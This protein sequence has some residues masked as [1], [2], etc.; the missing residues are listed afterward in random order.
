[1]SAHGIESIQYVA[2]LVRVLRMHV[3]PPHRVRRCPP[4]VAGSR[5]EGGYSH[6]PRHAGH[7]AGDMVGR[8]RRRRRNGTSSSRKDRSRSDGRADLTHRVEPTEPEGGLEQMCRSVANAEGGARDANGD[9]GAPGPGVGVG[10][11]HPA[12]P[13][14]EGVAGGE[15]PQLGGGDEG[16]GEGCVTE[17]ESQWL[18]EGERGEETGDERGKEDARVVAEDQAGGSGGCGAVGGVVGGVV[19]SGGG[20]CGGG[21]ETEEEHRENGE[22][23]DGC[24]AKH[25]NFPRFTGIGSHRTGTNDTLS[26][27]TNSS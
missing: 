6:L 15:G 26:T 2:K 8:T 12:D 4:N 17:A 21:R 27:R 7:A 25:H 23:G 9:D 19:V 14:E 11:G 3:A 18:R 1:M 24:V 16:A 13:D 10:G 22:R 20:C 5:V